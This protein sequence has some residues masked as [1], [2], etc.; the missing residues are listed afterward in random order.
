MNDIGMMKCPLYPLHILPRKYLNHHLEGNCEEALN[1][2]RKYF[3]K[4][5]LKDSI[6]PAPAHFLADVPDS[7]LSWHNKN[8]LFIL[9][10]DLEGNI[11]KPED[12]ASNQE[13]DSPD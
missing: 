3:Q 10:R 5:S 13:I 9:Q 7:V 4:H 11:I 12:F 1:M 8:L 6:K 2:L